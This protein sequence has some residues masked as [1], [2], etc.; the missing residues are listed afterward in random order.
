MEEPHVEGVAT[1]DDPESCSDSREA[2]AEALTGARMGTVLSREINH[3]GVPTL[4]TE[5]EGNTSCAANARRDRPCAV[6]DP[7]HVRNLAARE[8]GD[9]HVARR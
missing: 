2:A 6:G 1:H 4:L 5:A 3:I 7:W 8:P 9:P